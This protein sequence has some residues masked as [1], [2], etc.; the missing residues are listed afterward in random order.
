MANL[1]NLEVHDSISSAHGLVQTTTQN[2]QVNVNVTRAS[3]DQKMGIMS[4]VMFARKKRQ[5]RNVLS[6]DSASKRGIIGMS[7]RNS[8]EQRHNEFKKP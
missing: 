8:Y 4:N 1:M 7:P 3:M 5:N 6:I 2:S